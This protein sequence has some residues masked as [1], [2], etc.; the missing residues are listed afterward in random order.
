MKGMSMRYL[1]ARAAMATLVVGSAGAT[2]AAPLDDAS[3]VHCTLQSASLNYGR[4]TLQR[5]SPVAG[6][7]EAVVA[8]RNTATSLRRV[9]LWLSFPTVG[10]EIAVLQSGRSTITVVFFQD[11]QFAV[12]WA[13][14]RNGTARRQIL[15]ELAPGERKLLHLPVYALLQNPR[16]A[17]AGVYMAQVPVA[18]NTLEK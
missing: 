6:E 7:G 1:I 5:Q 4:L 2:H 8:C 15:L 13:E 11:A 9:E 10:P 17:A 12:R 3:A 18:I 14:D 16:D